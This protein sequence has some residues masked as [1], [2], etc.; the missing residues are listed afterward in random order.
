MQEKVVTKKIS[1][2]QTVELRKKL[3]CGF[4][5]IIE[6]MV[7][8]QYKRGTINKMFTC[9]RTMAPIVFE[10]ANKLIETIDKLKKQTK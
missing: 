10:A 6:E 3:P 1:D 5:K 7:G 2:D 9:S 8:G 4:G